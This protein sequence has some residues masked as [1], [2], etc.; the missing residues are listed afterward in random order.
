MKN[1]KTSRILVLVLSL[2]LLIGTAVGFAVSAA[3]TTETTPEI[4]G[5]NV[6]YKDVIYVMIAVDT[7]VEADAAAD[8]DITVKY[9]ID[10]EEIEKTATYVGNYK[11][12]ENNAEKNDQNYY[13][14]Y[15]TEG[16]AAKNQ[17]DDITAWIED[18]NGQSATKNVS[19]ASYLYQRLYKDGII[20]ATEET[21]VA[22]R[23]FY[24][25][26]LDY[27]AGAQKVLYNNATPAPETP[28]TL[29]T[30][31]GFVYGDGLL[32]NGK[33]YVLV[34]KGESVELVYSGTDGAT[35]GWNVT[36]Y[37]ENGATTSFHIGNTM[38]VTASAIVE[39]YVIS[40]TPSVI[41]FN[42]EDYTKTDI[43]NGETKIYDSYNFG[44]VYNVFRDAQTNTTGLN[45]VELISQSANDKAL[46][47]FAVDRADSN[48]NAPSTI[49]TPETIDSN[50]NATVIEFS[51][52]VGNVI[53]DDC[54]EY[55]AGVASLPFQ[56]IMRGSKNQ[57]HYWQLG[58]KAFNLSK[59]GVFT[60]AGV[61]V[62]RA[63]EEMKLSFVYSNTNQCVYVYSGG[64]YKTTLNFTDHNN[65]STAAFFD[66]SPT[67]ASFSIDA[68]NSGAMIDYTLD[69]IKA[70]N[71]KLN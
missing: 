15:A 59:T 39:P 31:L 37:G 22:K 27:I 26:H 40:G 52:T 54:A 58:W 71:I 69:D 47:I 28:K 50:A 48:D 33:D 20:A 13:P 60:I 70:Y 17:G 66:Y 65:G 61:E 51:L 19:V 10:G 11:I 29:V 9:V 5:I 32:V 41:D 46:H 4:E 68:N 44:R 49:I 38:N 7:P 18:A 6:Y 45:K 42:G 67:L 12:W 30:E 2:A 62:G 53:P 3:E 14:V 24:L 64:V 16:I 1:Y 63:N 25:A 21:D 8:P 55:T 57:N 34:K 23:D 35:F 56:V 36:T 43:M